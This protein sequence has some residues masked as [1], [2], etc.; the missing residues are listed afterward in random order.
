MLCYVING[1]DIDNNA[2]WFM[3]DMNDPYIFSLCPHI[4][5]YKVHNFEVCHD[6]VSAQPD[7]YLHLS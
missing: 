2:I 5:V 6:P 7:V 3:N 4:V 1:S